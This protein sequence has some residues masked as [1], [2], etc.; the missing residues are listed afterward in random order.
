MNI[1]YK[2]AEDESGNIIHIENAVSG[3]GYSCPGC[4][5]EM[6]L[7]NGQIR[8]RHFS[9]KNVQNCEGGGE[10]YLHETFKKLLVEKIKGNIVER[11]TLDI[12]FTCNICNGEHSFDLLYY[13]ADVKIEHS[14][15][16]CRPDLVLLDALGRVLFIIEIIVTHE[17]ENNVIE[18]CKKN[19]MVLIK[20]NLDDLNDLEN[21][22]NKI[23]RPSEVILFSQMRCPTTVQRHNLLMHQYMLQPLIPGG[24]RYGGSRIDAID[25]KM[26]TSANRSKSGNYRSLYQGRG[27]RK[28]R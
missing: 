14:L 10:G 24:R 4:K 28:R 15:D 3:Q 1:L 11:K 22:D 16:G 6:I 8:Q 27:S 21:I 18:Y 13:V 26:N 25:A 5:A 19:G 20:I 12:R 7:K 9:H 17:P 2:F 23:N